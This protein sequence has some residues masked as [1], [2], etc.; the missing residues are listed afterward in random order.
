MLVSPPEIVLVLL[1]DYVHW[2]KTRN[3]VDIAQGGHI[4]APPHVSSHPNAAARMWLLSL[5][6]LALHVWAAPKF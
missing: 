2:T 3:H 1:T 4:E 5:H 6:E